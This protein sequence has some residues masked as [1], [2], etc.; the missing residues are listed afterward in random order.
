VVTAYTIDP[1]TDL[2]KNSWGGEFPKF[3]GSSPPK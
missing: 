1:A 2:V 3:G